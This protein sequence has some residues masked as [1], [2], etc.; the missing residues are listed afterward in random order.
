MATVITTMVIAIKSPPINKI[1]KEGGASFSD[2]NGIIT[3]K[4]RWIYVY[5]FPDIAIFAF[6]HIS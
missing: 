5:L 2:L 4:Y 6:K 1:E 3:N